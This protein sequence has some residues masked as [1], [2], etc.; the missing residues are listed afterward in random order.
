MLCSCLEASLPVLLPNGIAKERHQET[1]LG[2]NTA[3][4]QRWWDVVANQNHLLLIFLFSIRIVCADGPLPQL[5]LFPI[6]E[7]SETSI[8]NIIVPL[9]ASDI[10]AET[11]I[12]P[13]YLNK[14]GIS[15]KKDTKMD[16]TYTINQSL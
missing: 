1:H 14:N 9:I 13:I 10:V 7:P 6:G 16:I 8:K 5:S 3:I 15:N 4:R 2:G 11:T 12:V